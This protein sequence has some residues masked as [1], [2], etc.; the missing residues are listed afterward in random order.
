MLYYIS[1]YGLNTHNWVTAGEPFS[2]FTDAKIAAQKLAEVQV[3]PVYIY[4]VEQQ[5]CI[6]PQLPEILY[7]VELVKSDRKTIQ[8]HA[9][10]CDEAVK[11]GLK[12]CPDWDFYAVYET[13]ED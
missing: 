9:K 8:V 10:T 12:I 6:E 7:D 1:K 2:T 4:S 13:E 11:I 3:V 5:D